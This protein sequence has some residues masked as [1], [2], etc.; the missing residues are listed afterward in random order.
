MAQ[1]FP[2]VVSL[3]YKAFR[4][5]L[6][7]REGV[8]R[9]I[10]VGSSGILFHADPPLEPGLRLE[11]SI[12]WPVPEEMRALVRLHA[13]AQIVRLRDDEAAVRLVRR[14]FKREECEAEEW[15]Q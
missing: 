14:E 1:R 5:G 8:G 9:T 2:M 3:E 12:H 10:N 7:I 4:H 11:L 15:P 6:L 13:L